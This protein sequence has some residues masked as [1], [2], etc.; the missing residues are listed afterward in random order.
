[1]TT[2]GGVRLPLLMRAL[3]Y[4]RLSGV[5]EAG[6]CRELQRLAGELAQL[7]PDEAA[8]A[9]AQDAL[10]QAFVARAASLAA[11]D[12]DHAALAHLPLKRGSIGYPGFGA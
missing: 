9:A 12:A 1:M 8:S 10:W 2:P 5:D 3:G 11:A 7:T 4:L 6:C